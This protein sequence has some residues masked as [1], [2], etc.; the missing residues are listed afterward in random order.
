VRDLAPYRRA[1]VRGLRHGRMGRAKC[2]SGISDRT[3]NSRG[4]IFQ[5]FLK[6]EH[7]LKLDSYTLS[8]GHHRIYKASCGTEILRRSLVFFACNLPSSN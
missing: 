6:P 1:D 4:E 8:R 2:N 5:D 3:W 7:S